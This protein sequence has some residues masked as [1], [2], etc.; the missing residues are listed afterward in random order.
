M[1]EMPGTLDILTWSIRSNIP[2]DLAPRLKMLFEDP[3][4]WW[5]GQFQKYYV[6]PRPTIQKMV[7]DIIN[8]YNLKSPI[9]CVHVRR[10][11]KIKVGM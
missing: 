4:A 1:I 9:A 6:K 2:A 7:D 8:G 3:F 10:S 11:E 5:M